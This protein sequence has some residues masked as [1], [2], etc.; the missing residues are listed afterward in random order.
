MHFEITKFNI[1]LGK[2]LQCFNTQN[3]I[4]HLDQNKGL[5]CGIFT[6]P[7]VEFSYVRGLATP[8]SYTLTTLTNLNY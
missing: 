5:K 8:K 2:G 3:Y 6:S 7:I 1:F 4:P